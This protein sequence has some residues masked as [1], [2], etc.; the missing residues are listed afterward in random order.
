LPSKASLCL[1]TQMLLISQ[2]YTA[3][4][5]YYQLVFI[6]AAYHCHHC[7]FLNVENTHWCSID[8]SFFLLN[9]DATTAGSMTMEM[10]LQNSGCTMGRTRT[11]SAK[12]RRSVTPSCSDGQ[13]QRSSPNHDAAP[14]Q[15]RF[16]VLFNFLMFLKSELPRGIHLDCL[17]NPNA[18]S[19][20][21][22]L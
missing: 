1:S 14:I 6:N 13:K 21:C 16:L 7:C 17:L 4:P 9:Q 2:R 18:S 8:N 15:S 12:K 20:F 5:V 22:C 19:P 11:S 10:R 3:L